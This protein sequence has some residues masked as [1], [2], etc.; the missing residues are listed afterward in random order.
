MFVTR[1]IDCDHKDLI[2]DVAYDFYGKR[3]ATCSSDQSVKVWDITPDGQWKCTASWKTHSGSVWKVT[4][5]HPEFGQ[6]LATCS[7]DR[8]AAVWEEL[9]VEGSSGER[10]QSHWVKRATF[11][12]SRTPVTDVKF[13]PKHLG[14]Q[15]ATCSTEGQLRIYDAPDIMNL[16]QW[17]LQHDISCRMQCSCVTW[18]HSRLHPPM[19]AVGSDDNTPAA[20]VI[21]FEYSE[22]TRR[23]IEIEAIS[24]YTD[25]VH[26]IAFAPN[27]G[28]SYNLLGIATKDVRILSITPQQVQDQMGVNTSYQTNQQSLSSSSP[29]KHE[30]KQVMQFNDHGAQVWRIAWNVT[31][32]ILASSGEDG[33]VRLWK[34]NYLENW[35]C[36]GVIKGDSFNPGS[37]LTYVSAIVS[38]QTENENR[39][40]RNMN[41]QTARYYRLSNINNPN[42]VPWH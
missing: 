5:A 7:F 4:W 36:V 30:I 42:N 2:H 16:S 20:K 23:W 9:I 25:P 1:S 22:S 31:G 12:D 11:V 34:A 39:S 21:I 6:V 8:T 18:S 3:L 40:D 27:V 28:L 41:K 29:L 32:T 33:T 19:I 26:D 14:L 24:F 17:P 35:K 38:D 10:N 37:N 15:L 13:A